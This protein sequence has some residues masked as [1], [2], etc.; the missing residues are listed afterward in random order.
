MHLGSELVGALQIMYNG[1]LFRYTI[2]WFRYAVYNDTTWDPATLSS[3][4]YAAASRINPGNIQAWNGN[5]SPFHARYYAHVVD[6]MAAAPSTLDSFYRYFRIS[7]MGHCGGGGEGERSI[8]QI[9][10]DPSSNVLMVFVWQVENGTAPE[11]IRD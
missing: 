1:E 6:T 9:S 2:D 10:L 5:L 3:R 4:D 11:T 8:R 7:G